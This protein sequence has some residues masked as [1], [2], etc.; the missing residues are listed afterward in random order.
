MSAK[1]RYRMLHR[2]IIGSRHVTAFGG[3]LKVFLDFFHR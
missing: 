2:L 3:V 1:L